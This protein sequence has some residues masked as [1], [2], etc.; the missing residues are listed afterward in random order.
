MKNNLLFLFSLL[1]ICPIITAQTGPGGVG[2]STNLEA[3]MDASNLTLNN[4]D[5]VSS[6]TDF[7]GNNNDAD[8]LTLIN[9]P[10]F[11]TNQV[12]SHPAINFDGVNDRLTFNSHLQNNGLTFFC[13]YQTSSPNGRTILNIENHR[14]IHQ[15]QNIRTRYLNPTTLTQVLSP[16]GSNYRIVES[17]T[18]SDSLS[19]TVVLKSDA[20][21]TTGARNHLRGSSNSRIGSHSSS[22]FFNG[23]LAEIIIYNENLNSARKNIISN[24]L[25]AKYDLTTPVNLYAYKTSYNNGVIGIGQEADGNHTIAR[26]S[27]ALEIS[28]P[29]TLI[30]GDYLLIGHD[31]AGFGTTTT[32]VPGGVDE[33]WDQ[34]WRVDE[35]GTPGNI[36]LEFFLGGNGFAAITDYV[37]LT[38]NVDGDFGNGGTSISSS[39]P[40][41]NAL[42]NS[43][44]FNNVN[45]IDGVYFTLA[46]S[47]GEIDAIS[48][49]DWNDITTWSC[50][51]IPA[52]GDIV[53]IGSPFNV[54]VDANSSARDLSVLSGATLSFSG[55][56]TLSLNGDFTTQASA[57][58]TS[59]T[60]AA[61]G[62]G[63][64]QTF[65]NLS[66]S[67]FSLNNLTSSNSSGL[68][69][70]NGDWS[71]SGSLEVSSGILNV[72]S[73]TSFT[74]TST[75]SATSQIL[76]SV[77]NAF[78]GNFT[79]QRF[80]SSRNA[81][82]ANLA[83]PIENATIADWDDDLF[84]SGVSGLDGN[85]TDGSGSIFYSVY[86]YNYQLDKHDTITSTSTALEPGK[87]YEVWLADN[88]TTYN[89]GT[90]DVVGVPTSGN[91]INAR[92]DQGW[93]LLG[94]PYHSFIEYDSIKTSVWI[95]DNYYIF[96]TDNGSYDFFNGAGKP[97]IAPSQGFWIN[98]IPGG[99]KAV[100][101][102][103][104]GKVN[105]NSSSFLRKKPNQK[106][107][108]RIRS[109]DNS[110]AHQTVFNFDVN[111]TK[112]IDDKD[113]YYLKS[114]EKR[115]PAI[116]SKASNSEEGLIFNSL[117]PFE[118][119]QLIPIEIYAGIDG[120][121]S[122][123]A[124][125][126][127]ELY[128]EY[129]CVYLKDKAT[130]EAVDLSVDQS[131]QFETTQGTSDRF[132][133]IIS[134]SYTECEKLIED[135]S[136]EQKLDHQLSL[137]N[138]YG[139][140]FVDYT[141]DGNQ[142]QVE[143][144]ILN[145][146]GQEVREAISFGASNAGTYPLQNLQDLNGI[147]LIQVKTKDGFLNKTV[148]L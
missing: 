48:S 80:I 75:A 14:I 28:N 12:N 8:Q 97:A 1:S 116:Y 114:P 69:I 59:G 92:I 11:L 65:T 50:S 101:F 10:I 115:A 126:V 145:M 133:L 105:S 53:N 62:S 88:L 82:Y 112:N 81:N 61:V 131:Y 31:G 134:N 27:G 21:S 40:V 139:Q 63:T 6:W 15:N 35:T 71:L 108:L 83:S 51:C 18:G 117:N 136:F 141:L 25:G 47:D 146:K 38:E 76:P 142:Q 144:R 9:Q 24:Y 44:S 7:S 93:N 128:K 96:N 100:D 49:G 130:N 140:W 4:N 121:Y 30:D 58:Y 42:N 113:A 43:I 2:N 37:L 137:R 33:R 72:S 52:L 95:P 147:Y 68:D 118:K 78:A 66:G 3:W 135:A 22:N 84:M 87:G 124:R 143:I 55:N 26:G 64:V 20:N 125:N 85:A 102:R 107:L 148:Q 99:N 98:K 89:G 91:N 23:N 54:T 13:V 127:N 45:L 73:A 39:T 77:A 70:V 60:I 57:T 46:E 29:T 79:I 67:T 34:V 110:F 106:F 122:I 56:D 90:I 119:S 36:D 109:N 19:G 16:L 132:E 120:S 32:N 129:S 103:E 138:A 123:D 17:S 111:S 74:L 94:N 86:S 104:E 41:Y 5:P